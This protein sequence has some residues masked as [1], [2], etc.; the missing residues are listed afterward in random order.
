MTYDDV[1]KRDDGYWCRICGGYVGDDAISWHE[2]TDC[3]IELRSRLDA[4]PNK[5]FADLKAGD[6]V[7]IKMPAPRD[8]EQPM[9]PHADDWKDT[10]P[11]GVKLVFTLGD[12]EIE[13]VRA[14]EQTS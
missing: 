6:V 10:F 9:I 13:A 4:M 14:N 12:V 11:E 2:V 7:W 8:G 3:L 1:V 5:V